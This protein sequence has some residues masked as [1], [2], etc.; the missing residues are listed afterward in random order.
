M[1]ARPPTP[2]RF[3]AFYRTLAEIAREQEV[4]RRKQERFIVEVADEIDRE[5]PPPQFRP[6]VEVMGGFLFIE[7]GA[8][9]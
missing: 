9:Q 8:V 2:A 3:T 6:G 4:E 1:S 7:E 5:P